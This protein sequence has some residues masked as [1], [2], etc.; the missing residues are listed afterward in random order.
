MHAPSFAESVNVQCT[1]QAA[2]VNAV[3]T[4]AGGKMR[5]NANSNLLVSRPAMS[6]RS[7]GLDNSSP[8]ACL[9]SSRRR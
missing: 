3:R 1:T 8:P 7:P 6:H 5:R 9:S 2:I 4:S